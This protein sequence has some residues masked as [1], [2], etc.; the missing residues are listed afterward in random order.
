MCLMVLDGAQAI[1]EAISPP[2]KAENS[3]LGNISAIKSKLCNDDPEVHSRM[4]LLGNMPKTWVLE[5]CGH[6]I[7]EIL[8]D[9]DGEGDYMGNRLSLMVGLGGRISYVMPE[10]CNEVGAP[11][12]GELS[13]NK[14]N[15]DKVATEF[16]LS[17]FVKLSDTDWQDP[18]ITS[19]VINGKVRIRSS[20]T[21]D[22]IEYLIV[23]PSLWPIPQ[24]STAFVLDLYDLKFL[25]FDKKGKLLTPDALIKNKVN[26]GHLSIKPLMVTLFLHPRNRIHGWEEQDLQ[27]QLHKSCFIPSASQSHVVDLS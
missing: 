21:V 17:C 24:I 7:I 22:R 3:D 1:T 14:P 5:E 26:I 9:S 18:N 15:Y 2:I 23:I 16:D 19:L 11:A 13:D 6:K 27:I 12:G 10:P 8:S 20:V 4:S 25:I